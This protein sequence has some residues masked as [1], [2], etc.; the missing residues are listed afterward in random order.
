MCL[1][2]NSPGY[3]YGGSS[4]EDLFLLV[5]CLADSSFDCCQ[6]ALVVKMVDEVDVDIEV[7]KDKDSFRPLPPL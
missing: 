4:G 5:V 1:S 7:G 3:G 6:V 2:G